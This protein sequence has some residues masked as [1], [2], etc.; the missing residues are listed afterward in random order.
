MDARRTARLLHYHV[1]ARSQVIT[2]FHSTGLVTLTEEASLEWSN[3]VAIELF[4][5]TR[6]KARAAG[7]CILCRR[8][9]TSPRN[10]SVAGQKGC[11]ELAGM[12][13]LCFDGVYKDS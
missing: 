4:G 11:E 8:K 1:I 7:V 10:Y 9:R 5:W 3:E 2:S 6:D 13:E 12:G